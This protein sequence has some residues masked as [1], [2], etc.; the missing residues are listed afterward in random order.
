MAEHHS[1]SY[2]LDERYNFDPGIRRTAFIG[3]GVGVG[4]IILGIILTFFGGHEAAHGAGAEH[5]GHASEHAGHAAEHGP[6]WLKRLFANLWINNVYFAGIAVCGVF[7]V[8]VQYVSWAGWST[9]SS[10]SL[11]VPQ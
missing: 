7:F 11:K 9:P 3:I 6:I 8:A 2:N 1:V 10:V 4:L 5:A